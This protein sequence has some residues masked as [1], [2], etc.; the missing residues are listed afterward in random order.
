M[1]EKADPVTIGE[2]RAILEKIPRIHD[3]CL[4]SLIVVDDDARGTD[5]APG[6]KMEGVFDYVIKPSNRGENLKLYA[7]GEAVV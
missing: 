1:N 5:E 7:G 6:I 4:I 3:R 2:L